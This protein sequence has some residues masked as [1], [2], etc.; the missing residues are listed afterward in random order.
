MVYP[1]RLS[2]G[3][4][5]FLECMPYAFF[6]AIWYAAKQKVMITLNY[7]VKHWAWAFTVIDRSS[8]NELEIL[9]SSS[10]LNVKHQLALY[11]THYF[12]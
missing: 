12:S 9:S 8:L 2:R 11:V 1:F 6:F 3:N 5:L 4:T 10:D 7:N